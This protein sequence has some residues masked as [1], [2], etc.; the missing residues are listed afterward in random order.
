MKAWILFRL[1]SKFEKSVRSDL[2]ESNQERIY[3]LYSTS[4]Y[5]QLTF[6]IGAYNTYS[7]TVYF[8]KL[9]QI[10][11]SLEILLYFVYVCRSRINNCKY[12][13][14]VVE[15]IFNFLYPLLTIVLP[16]SWMDANLMAETEASTRSTGH[17]KEVVGTWAAL[18]E[19]R[20]VSSR[21]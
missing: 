20:R 17:C 12:I 13:Y 8:N 6:E 2:T 4:M 15:E 16:I 10:R 7:C 18:I 5:I 19:V 11:K 3:L 14:G 21:I 9:Q 1:L